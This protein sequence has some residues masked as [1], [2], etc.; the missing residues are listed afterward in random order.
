MTGPERPWLAVDAVVFD[1]IGRVLL[2]RRKYSPFQGH[3]ALPGG[4]V[5]LGETTEAAVLRELKEETG[6]DGASPRLIG[7]YSDPTRDTRHHVV[8]IAYLVAP[9]SYDVRGGDDASDAE[10]V[11]NWREKSLAFDHDQI[12]S[13]AL[14]VA[15]A[16]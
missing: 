14:H 15:A 6:I 12:I 5:E 4:F 1:D 13:D 16:R 9:K 11:E 10:F 2:I 3:F 7:V 8:S